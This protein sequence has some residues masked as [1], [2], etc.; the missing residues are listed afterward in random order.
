MEV[1]CASPKGKMSESIKLAFRQV[2]S[3]KPLKSAEQLS[4]LS[5]HKTYFSED[6]SQNVP[7]F[8]GLGF[9][10]VLDEIWSPR[11]LDSDWQEQGP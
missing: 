10:H 8:S 1:F 9:V 7:P 2:F 5:E 3:T 6:P 11:M 4:S